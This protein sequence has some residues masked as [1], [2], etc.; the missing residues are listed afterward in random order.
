MEISYSFHANGEILALMFIFF[1]L[2]IFLA[3]NG[4]GVPW[5]I[6]CRQ[7]AGFLVPTLQMGVGCLNAEKKNPKSIWVWLRTIS[8]M[9]DQHSHGIRPVE[10]TE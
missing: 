2:K 7:A 1:H 9:N 8:F 5:L 3:G 6:P 10:Y 4:V